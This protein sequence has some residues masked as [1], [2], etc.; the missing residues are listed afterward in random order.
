MQKNLWQVCFLRRQVN[1]CHGDKVPPFKIINETLRNVGIKNQFYEIFCILSVFNS[2]SSLTEV[3]KYLK[4][5]NY[6]KL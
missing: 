2:T 3:S 5:I 4:K 1:C 6:Q